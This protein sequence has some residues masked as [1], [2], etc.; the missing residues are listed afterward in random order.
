MAITSREAPWVD[1]TAVQP[2]RAAN[3]RET[4]LILLLLRSNSL[5]ADIYFY[6]YINTSRT[7]AK[8][9]QSK[10]T[11]QYARGNEHDLPVSIFSE[12]IAQAQRKEIVR[13]CKSGF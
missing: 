1:E 8:Q 9:T 10:S 13:V 3:V 4:P 11:V 12:A 5:V 6:Q 2:Q 7:L